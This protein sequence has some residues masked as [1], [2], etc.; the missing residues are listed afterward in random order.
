[1][2]HVASLASGRICDSTVDY[3]YLCACLCV[4]EHLCCVRCVHC[5]Y[6]TFGSLYCQCNSVF[7]TRISTA[8]CFLGGTS[9]FYQFI[10]KLSTVK[11][12]CS[13]ARSIDKTN[14]PPLGFGVWV[15]CVTLS[16]I[17]YLPLYP[18]RSLDLDRT[19]AMHSA[20]YVSIPRHLVLRFA[21]EYA[22]PD[23]RSLRKALFFV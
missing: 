22:F 2:I 3:D 14:L 18:K 15:E 21:S 20:R 9:F 8:S 17:L 7:S 16:S 19:R 1:M 10:R 6:C 13:R 4:I 23:R 11:K 5:F 12:R